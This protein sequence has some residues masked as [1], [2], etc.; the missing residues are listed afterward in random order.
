MNN[1]LKASFKQLFTHADLLTMDGYKVTG[2][3][4]HGMMTEE[5]TIL[6]F[7]TPW[8]VCIFAIPMNREIEVINGEFSMADRN[9]VMHVFEVYTLEKTSR[10]SLA[11]RPMSVMVTEKVK[12]LEGAPI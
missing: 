12:H 5:E 8:S 6:K 11:L 4:G 9:G 10:I 1:T 3:E 2:V 7:D